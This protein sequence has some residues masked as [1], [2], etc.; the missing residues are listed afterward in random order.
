MAG[1]E[2]ADEFRSPADPVEDHE[3][4]DVMCSCSLLESLRLF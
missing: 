1:L 4:T 2:G 3:A